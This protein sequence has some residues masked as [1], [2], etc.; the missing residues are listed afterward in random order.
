MSDEQARSDRQQARAERISV[1]TAPPILLAVGLSLQLGHGGPAAVAGGLS[2]LCTLIGLGRHERPASYFPTVITCVRSAIT[3]AMLGLGHLVSD[4]WIALT[5]L[6]VFAMDG[7]DGYFARRLNAT[8]VLGA[9]LDMETDAL[10]VLAACT[11]LC[12]RGVG[13]WV[14]IG[15]LLRYVY[16]LYVRLFSA[17]GEVPRVPLF[18]YAFGISIT[19]FTSAFLLEGA[20]RS[21][22]P[23][24]ATGMLSY[25]F[26]HAFYWSSRGAAQR[27]SQSNNTS[28]PSE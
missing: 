2:L 11:Q 23:A 15:A 13:P 3:C 27:M 14:L 8:S 6:T 5:I 21:V 7:L 25:S 4:P 24:L 26:G 20:W 22:G 9:R 12:L 28:E 19:G 16:V 18:R 17:H 10:L 1:L